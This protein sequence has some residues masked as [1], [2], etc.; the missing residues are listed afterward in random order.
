MTNIEML[1]IAL[2][3]WTLLLCSKG[4]SLVMLVT[5]HVTVLKVRLMLSECRRSDH[6]PH[7]NYIM[8]MYIDE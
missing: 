6:N 2:N 4:K 5:A 3:V 7:H 8:Y 1:M